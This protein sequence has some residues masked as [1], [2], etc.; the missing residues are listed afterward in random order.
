MLLLSAFPPMVFAVL[1]PSTGTIQ[2]RTP[3]TTGKL[4]VNGPGGPFESGNELDATKRPIDYTIDPDTSELLLA[5]LDGDLNLSAAINTPAPV[6]VWKDG[7]TTLTATQL[8]Q[9]FIDAN[10]AGKILT[11]TA[12]P[13]ITV[14]T[15]TGDPNSATIPLQQSY[16]FIIP[17][18]LTAPMAGSLSVNG[19]SFAIDS[20][21]PTTGFVKAKY[22]VLYGGNAIN[23]TNVTWSTSQ[24]DWMTVDATG[25]VTFPSKPTSA[26]KTYTITATPKAGGAAQTVTATVRGW[27]VQ[28]NSI[29]VN[30]V[31]ANAW[32]DGSLARGVLPTVAQLSDSSV[33]GWDTP[34]VSAAIVI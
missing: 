11:A 7:N 20:G 23:N 3:T 22:Q 24:P 32:C 2:G 9:T 14:S 16:V 19:A 12:I 18:P 10:K 17:A 1:S 8:S 6:L 31:A 27:F 33:T 15:S 34:R 5:D 29:Q 21:F 30:W 25:T 13:S 26:Q 4:F 28:K